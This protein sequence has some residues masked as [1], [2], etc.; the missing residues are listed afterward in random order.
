MTV[1][2]A[3]LYSGSSGNAAYVR[4]GETRLLVDAGL[5]GR[6]ITDALA[7]LGE[8]GEGISALL[9]THEHSDH[10]AGVGVLSRKFHLPIYA[11]AGTW[12]G[13][14]RKIGKIPPENR[15]LV[16]A[17]DDFLL[18]G[19]CVSPFRIPHDAEEPVGYAFSRDG[20][21]IGVATDLGHL[22]ES[23]LSWLPG[24]DLLLL[25]SNHDPDMLAAGPYS[26]DLQCRIRGAKG[27]LSNADAG[28]AA[29]WL[30]RAGTRHII[31]GHLSG[32]NNFPELA[33][34]TVADALDRAGL[35]PGVDVG[36]DVARRD[37]VGAIYHLEG[38]AAHVPA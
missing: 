12:R 26:Y 22:S 14:E 24:C 34:R 38:G 4:M 11:T 16:V 21:K 20:M 1:D 35:A 15:R 7:Q 10:T 27:H 33:W 23:W 25:E 6:R 18:G 29:V 36:L 30:T 17:G 5:P 32:E 2:F 28:E 31:L 3:P 37:R 9:V 8:T 13:M 19:I